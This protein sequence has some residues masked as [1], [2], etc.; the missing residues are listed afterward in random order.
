MERYWRVGIMLFL[1]LMAFYGWC[2][3]LECGLPLPAGPLSAGDAGA[4]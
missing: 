4:S 3:S 2:L 1:A